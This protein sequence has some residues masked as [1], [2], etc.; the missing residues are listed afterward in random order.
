MYFHHNFEPPASV[1]EAVT[2]LGDVSEKAVASGSKGDEDLTR[3]YVDATRPLKAFI[4]NHKAVKSRSDLLEQL[5]DDPSKKVKLAMGL[6]RYKACESFIS[7]WQNRFMNLDISIDLMFGR[8]EFA[9]MYMDSALP[10]VWDFEHDIIVVINP[11]EHLVDKLA[12]RGQKRIFI[13]E[14]NEKKSES[15]K[16]HYR[17]QT[18]DEKDSFDLF[19]VN[20][21]EHIPVIIQYQYA[22]KPP[23]AGRVMNHAP[24]EETAAEELQRT[25]EDVI[26]KDTSRAELQ[27]KMSESKRSKYFNDTELMKTKIH[28]AVINGITQA[29]AYS[30]T[31]GKW[32]QSW[33]KNALQNIPTM[34]KSYYVDRLYGK[35]NEVPGILICPGPS[36]DKNIDQLASLK[37]RCLLIAT[38]HAV[39]ALE[40][41]K[42]TPDIVIHIDPSPFG[43]DY[44]R[45]HD[46]SKTE[47]LLLA[48]TVDPFFFNLE[49]KS[50]GWLL[51][52]ALGDSWITD[53]IPCSKDAPALGASVSTAGFLL[54]KLFGCPKLILVGTDLAGTMEDGD[55]TQEWY[56]SGSKDDENTQLF[57]KQGYYEEI[58]TMYKDKHPFIVPGWNGDEV[59]T[60][61]D[62]K[63][64]L[65]M[66]ECIAEGMQHEIK[67][68]KVEIF[69][70]TEGGAYIKGF[71]HEPLASVIKT[72]P[73]FEDNHVG[74]IFDQIR[75][76]SFGFEP[77]NVRKNMQKMFSLSR[78][79]NKNLQFCIKYT[80]RK[81]RKSY[82]SKVLAKKQTKLS[83]QLKKA[84]FIKLGVMTVLEKAF[85]NDKFM[86]DVNGQIDK[87]NYMYS[88]AL[89][90]SKGLSSELQLALGKF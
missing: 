49:A 58:A 7:E 54:A 68:K 1:L 79:I 77:K 62:F 22:Q 53:M 26:G 3:Q 51:G 86:T 10:A 56:A 14:Q 33:V 63:I 73:N 84:H 38:S 89:K 28:D 31:V 4:R 90:I 48:A 27:T 80:D 24:T 59:Y 74:K 40:R 60:K 23:M 83:S 21:I 9:D 11:K 81:N 52:Q 19:V 20:K 43:N 65:E 61:F 25:K 88:E 41:A 67:S 35:F 13:F 30:N 55:M 47:M 29:L 69:N 12:Q 85:A 36:L 82:D 44:L 46:L 37:G 72:L 34:S 75:Q 32:S 6:Q 66:F 57:S 64:Y 87:A 8:E 76:N 18:I 16:E 50:H 2:R 70:C 78:E 45:G 5:S 15:I 42:V 71:I 17:N 39:S